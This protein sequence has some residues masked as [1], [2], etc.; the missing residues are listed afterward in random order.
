M[1]FL[2]VFLLCRREKAT[3]NCPF[4]SQIIKVRRNF[5]TLDECAKSQREGEGKGNLLNHLVNLIT[6]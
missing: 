5:Q 1:L 2:V 6:L 3:V 4:L